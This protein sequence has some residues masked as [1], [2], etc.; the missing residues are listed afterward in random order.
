[1]LL[2]TLLL[3]SALFPQGPTGTGPTLVINEINYDDSGTDDVEYVELYNASGGPID[4]TGFVLE[5]RDPSGLNFAHALSPV[6][7]AAGDYWVLGFATAPN[8]DQVVTG[9]STGWLEND[10]ESVTLLD[11]SAAIVDTLIYESNKGIAFG[12]TFAE[13]EGIWD[14]HTLTQTAGLEMSWSRVRDGW[15]TNDN[16]RDFHHQRWTPGA[17]NNQAG[18]S[19]VEDFDLLTVGANVPGWIGNFKAARAIDPTVVGPL[20]GANNL[21]P[22]AI[23][24]SPQGGNAAIFWDETGGG[25][26]TAW[27]GGPGIETSFEAWVYIAPSPVVTAGQSESWS[28]GIQGTSGLYNIPDPSGLLGTGTWYSGMSSW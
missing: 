3:T 2:S 25:N 21:N 10:N 12:P 23:P 9:A 27:L 8:V 7:L 18:Q 19:Y 28:I 24:A 6:V 1:M 16:G 13:G 17:S 5:S 22:N 14:N 26:Y 15:D 11:P 4:M 20:L